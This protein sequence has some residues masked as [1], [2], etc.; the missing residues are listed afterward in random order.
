MFALWTSSHE[1]PR[2][3]SG[4]DLFL[5]ATCDRARV[6]PAMSIASLSLILEAAFRVRA[7][8]AFHRSTYASG[9]I[10]TWPEPPPQTVWPRSSRLHCAP[11]EPA[12]DST[13]FLASFESP[14]PRPKLIPRP[15]VGSDRGLHDEDDA[16]RDPGVSSDRLSAVRTA[17]GVVAFFLAGL[18]SSRRSWRF[19]RRTIVFNA[20]Y[21]F[22]A[23]RVEGA[24]ERFQAVVRTRD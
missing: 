11:A 6:G 15:L 8:S 7:L 2:S 3:W 24:F 17:S 9:C 10:R 20:H 4:G 12:G 23:L 21:Q 18:T 14:T 1:R 5:A 19:T 22:E 13:T 16:V